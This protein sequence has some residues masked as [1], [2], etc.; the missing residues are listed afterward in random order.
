M[1]EVLTAETIVVVQT[2]KSADE[3]FCSGWAFTVRALALQLIRAA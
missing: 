2:G 3:E 1:E